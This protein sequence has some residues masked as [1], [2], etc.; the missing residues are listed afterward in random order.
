[1]LIKVWLFEHLIKNKFY[2]SDVTFEYCRE[3]KY[4]PESLI[5]IHISNSYGDFYYNIG[6]TKFSSS[7]NLDLLESIIKK[8]EIDINFYVKGV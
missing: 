7:N 2:N 5:F 1:M 6:H 4:I 3:I 8:Y